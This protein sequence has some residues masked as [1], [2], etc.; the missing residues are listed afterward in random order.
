MT[1]QWHAVLKYIEERISKTSFQTWFTGTT[2]EIITNENTIIITSPNS[3]GADWIRSHYSDL[4]SIAMVEVT[5]HSFKVEVI[6]A[7]KSDFN[8]PTLTVNTATKENNYEE[9]QT[10]K[11]KDLIDLLNKQSTLILKQQ[12]QIDELEKRIVHLESKTQ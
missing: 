3:F 11:Y 2:A 5:G 6:S 8:P 12:V 10:D 9:L 1:E 4:I 7:H